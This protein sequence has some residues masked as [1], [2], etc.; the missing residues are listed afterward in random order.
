MSNRIRI[1]VTSDVHGSIFPYSYADGSAQKKGYAQLYN[2]IEALRDENTLLLDNGDSLEGSPLSFFHYH[3]YPDKTAPVT[4][5]MHAMQ[6]DY[7]NVGNHDFNYGEDAL[8]IHFNNVGAPCITSNYLYKGVPYGPNYVIREI[9]GKKIALI[10]VTTQ[11]IPHWET[12]EHL[13]E[14]AFTDAFETLKKNVALAKKLEKPDY[15]IGLYHGGFERDLKTGFLSE[16][17]TGENEGY[18]MMSQIPDLDILLAGHQHI[19]SCGT[20]RNIVYTETEADGTELACVDIYPDTNVIEP[21][22]L[23]G[24]GKDTPAITETI[25]AEEQECQ[26][27]LDRTLGTTDVDLRVI[28]ENDA[29]LHKTQLITFL[30]HV[31]MEVTGADIAATALFLFATGFDRSI[32]MRNLVSTYVY[33][34]TLVVKKI[35]GK[36][37]REYLEKDAE[38]WAITAQ[39]AIGIDK[40]HDFP[41][42]QHY[43]YD[44][45]D[46]IE[47][48]IQVSK[49]IGQR[50]IAL[51]RNG[52]EI[53]DE[54][55]FT[56]CVNNYRAS[57]GGNFTMLTKCPTVSTNLSSMVELLADYIMQHKVISFEPVNNITVIK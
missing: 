43:N 40:F 24:E 1:L 41:T 11:Y 10:G 19:S 37:L 27:W 34:N 31:Q 25:Q 36:I 38:F 39:G 5:V 50:I 30:N 15:I 47:Y 6:Y 52:K 23:R 54:D 57:G 45:M 46:G 16:E 8:M 20:F 51:T 12:K 29:R 48:T 17:E 32:T 22:L 4:A 56:L 49:P 14:S 3:T 53:Q 18:K 7:I 33:P 42:P 35:T 44:M 28:D 55:E 9:A 21:R 2:L 26:V 13:K